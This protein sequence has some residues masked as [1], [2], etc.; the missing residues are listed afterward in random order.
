MSIYNSF[1]SISK[2]IK[3]RFF[4]LFLLSCLFFGIILYYILYGTYYKATLLQSD[5]NCKNYITATRTTLSSFI[6]EIFSST[7]MINNDADL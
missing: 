2:S 1:K 4:L 7:K 3:T 6:N 5:N